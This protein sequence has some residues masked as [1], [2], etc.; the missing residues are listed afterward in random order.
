M[1]A[2]PLYTDQ[3]IFEDTGFV[4]FRLSVL[5]DTRQASRG[6]LEL[7][8]CEWERELE[9]RVYSQDIHLLWLQP[10]CSLPSTYPISGDDG[11][12]FG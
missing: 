6:T 9:M 5:F 8:E 7:S 2:L 11:G 4:S 3:D 10:V 1:G 12:A